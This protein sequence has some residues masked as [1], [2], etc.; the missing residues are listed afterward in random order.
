M[1]MARRAADLVNIPT[2]KPEQVRNYTRHCDELLT[3]MISEF[4]NRRLEL[5]KRIYALLKEAAK[6]GVGKGEDK[7]IRSMNITSGFLAASIGIRMARAGL[8]RVYPSLEKHAG[9]EID[10]LRDI[11]YGK[12]KGRPNRDDEK[13]EV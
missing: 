3:D 8:R 6:K 4:V 13:F 10:G 9:I 2:R 7:W 5:N 11:K 1:T 12:G